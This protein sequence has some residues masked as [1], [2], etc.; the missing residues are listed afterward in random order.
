MS[1]E[2]KGSLQRFAPF[3]NADVFLSTIR[4]YADAGCANYGTVWSY[5]PDDMPSRIRWFA[6]EVMPN[7]PA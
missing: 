6:R 1:G 7:A 2:I 3:E 5:P 4:D